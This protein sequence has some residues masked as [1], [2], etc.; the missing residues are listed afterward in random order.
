M[1][2]FGHKRK[3]RIL[4][5]NSAETLETSRGIN[6]IGAPATVRAKKLKHSPEVREKMDEPNEESILGS[7]D[8]ERDGSN[9]SVSEDGPENFPRYG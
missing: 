9:G 3:F 8:S 1:S 2:G 6:V 4:W 5:S 7:S